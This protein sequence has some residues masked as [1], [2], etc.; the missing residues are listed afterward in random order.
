MNDSALQVF[1]SVS[2]EVSEK[3]HRRAVESGS[4]PADVSISLEEAL[5]RGWISQGD[6]D[7]WTKANEAWRQAHEA[8]SSIPKDDATTSGLWTGQAN[9]LAF[10]QAAYERGDDLTKLRDELLERLKRRRAQGAI[11]P[12]QY[13][14]MRSHILTVFGQANRR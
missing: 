3:I 1:L 13:E 11:D 7:R 2:K 4:R 5:T 9:A 14:E 8:R 10:F 12:T 6:Y